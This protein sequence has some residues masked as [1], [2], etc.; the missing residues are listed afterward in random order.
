MCA[1]MG[2]TV[3]A[4][5]SSDSGRDLVQK[6]GKRIA[7]RERT[8]VLLYSTLCSCDSVFG[9]S[10]VWFRLLLKVLASLNAFPFHSI[11]ERRMPSIIATP[12]R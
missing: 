3:I 1:A 11:Q 8:Y 2:M 12:M 9:I 7:V 4:T 10:P 5:A 6:N